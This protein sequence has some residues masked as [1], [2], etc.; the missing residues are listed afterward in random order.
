[1]LAALERLMQVRLHDA[2]VAAPR[3]VVVAARKQMDVRTEVE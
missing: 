1:M 3:L 2:R